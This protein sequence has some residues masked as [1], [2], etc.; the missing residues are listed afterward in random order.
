MPS[1]QAP[2]C[3]L[4]RLCTPVC[5]YHSIP[6]DQDMPF[7]ALHAPLNQHVIIL[8]HERRQ[9]GACQKSCAVAELPD[10]SRCLLS[11]RFR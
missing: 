7:Y 9:A 8:L 3:V 5:S 1:S 4:L 6:S 10:R 2:W 11:Q